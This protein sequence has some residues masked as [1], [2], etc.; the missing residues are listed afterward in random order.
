MSS[1][2][3]YVVGFCITFLAICVM[4]TMIRYRGVPR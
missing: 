3:F 1:A 4:D 2:I